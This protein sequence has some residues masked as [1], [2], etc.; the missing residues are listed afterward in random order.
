MGISW[1]RQSKIIMKRAIH[2]IEIDLWD[3]K[4]YLLYVVNQ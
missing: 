3:V 4:A 1:A 2:R